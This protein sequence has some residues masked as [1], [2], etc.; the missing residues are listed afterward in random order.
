MRTINNR[1]IQIDLLKSR[2]SKHFW[3]GSI[4]SI[5]LLS[6][7]VSKADSYP[8]F[9]EFSEKNSGRSVNCAMCHT[10]GDGPT[11]EGP[12]QIGSLKAEEI[13]RLNSAR[14]ALEP[15]SQVESPIL[16]D[17][18]NLIIKSL[19]KRKVLALRDEPAQLSIALGNR[20]DLDKDGICD[21]QEYFDGTDPLNAEHGDPLK[22]FRINLSKYKLH[23]CLALLAVA[24]ISFGIVR[25]L[26]AIEILAAVRRS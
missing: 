4:S 23:I 20:S 3:F 13:A 16:N 10:S 25:L 14:A 5:F 22:L 26:K 18:G 21:G 9:Q 6:C 11:G 8:Q 1:A 2:L 24:S 19:G 7:F 15:G 17:F 12:G